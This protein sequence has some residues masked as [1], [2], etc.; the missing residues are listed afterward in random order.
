M[1]HVGPT[2]GNSHMRPRV[3]LEGTRAMRAGADINVWGFA[4]EREGGRDQQ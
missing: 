2:G 1:S 4:A 3:R